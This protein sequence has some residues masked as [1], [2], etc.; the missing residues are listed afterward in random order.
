MMILKIIIFRIYLASIALTNAVVRHPVIT[1]I[2][3][4]VL[5]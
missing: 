1:K 2:Y 3:I 4:S 5:N